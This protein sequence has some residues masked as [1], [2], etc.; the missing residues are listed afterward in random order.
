MAL[1][2]GRASEFPV[3]I[4][5]LILSIQFGLGVNLFAASGLLP[6]AAEDYGISNTL[7]SLFVAGPVLLQAV[8]GL[9][10]S[11]LVS[12]W[13]PQRTVVAGAVMVSSS[14]AMAL[15]TSYF[16]V[17]VIRLIAGAGA[18]LVIAG[19]GPVIKG[20]FSNRY[21]PL[22]NTL[23]LVALSG[24]I[25][26]GVSVAVPLS[27]WV[28]WET[29]LAL[30]GLVM[31]VPTLA[32]SLVSLDVSPSVA[33]GVPARRLG[34]KEIRAVLS[35]RTVGGLVVADALVFV[36][37]AALTTWLPTFLSQ[38]RGIALEEAAF[39]TGLLPA[40]GM[41]AVVVGGVI[42]YRFGPWRPLIGIAGLLVGV[43]GFASFLLQ[44]PAAIAV[45]IV[46]LGVGTWVYQPAFH[47]VPMQLPWMTSEKVAVVWGAS[48]TIA[49]VGQFIAPIV[50][51]ASRDL[52]GSFVPGFAIWALLAW[53]LPFVAYVLDDNDVASNSHLPQPT[54]SIK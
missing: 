18:G 33:S 31:V 10:A 16:A 26:V 22:M 21:L 23:F 34:V 47:T 9:P 37:Y 35:D 14:V 12:R 48:M 13:G 30:F 39:L 43:S 2:S 3:G 40:V 20:S 11:S 44:R 15:F 41:L 19:T 7:V 42:S 50:V 6:L 52:F 51:G 46:L 54:R 36:Q 25:S 1:E 49:G 28:Q 53:S 29:A 4:A 5:A 32:W 8:T 45:A 27:N 24:G 17:L 38:D